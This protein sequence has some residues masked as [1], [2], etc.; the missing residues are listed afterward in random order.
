MRPARG[1]GAPDVRPR[2]PGRGN[3]SQRRSERTLQDLDLTAQD[4]S[5]IEP[6]FGRATSKSGSA[7]TE[8]AGGQAPNARLLSQRHRLEGLTKSPPA[9]GLDLAENERRSPAEDEVQLALA[10]AP[11]AL[12]HLVAAGLVP[13]RR[14]LLSGCPKGAPAGPG[15]VDR[16][17]GLDRSV[18][19]GRLR[20]PRYG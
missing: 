16:V 4:R 9:T 11:V 2:W 6:Q 14:S 10:A 8:P 19:A 13:R 7:L 3:D 12:D 18:R 17:G 15:A 5:H 1:W 20:P